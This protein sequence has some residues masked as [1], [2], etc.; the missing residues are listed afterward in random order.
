MDENTM[1]ELAALCGGAGYARG[2][3]QTI[4]ADGTCIIGA[5]ISAADIRETCGNPRMSDEECARIMLAYAEVFPD[6]VRRGIAEVARKL[7]IRS[8]GDPIEVGAYVIRD[9][10][11]AYLNAAAN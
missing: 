4:G 2:P 8:F 11:V 3:I 1:M 5:G 10:C 6:E 9:G 7:G